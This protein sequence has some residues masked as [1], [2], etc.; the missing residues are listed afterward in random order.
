MGALFQR[1]LDVALRS[2]AFVI[3]AAA[4]AGVLAA[5]LLTWGDPSSGVLAND[6]IYGAISI[7]QATVLALLLPWTAA[8]CTAAERGDDLVLL[9]AMTAVQPSRVVLVRFA[10]VLAALAA[11]LGTGLP[12]TILAVRMSNASATQ[13]LASQALMLAI[14]VAAGAFVAVWRQELRDRL[15]AW[16]AAEASTA[17]I[18][19]IAVVAVPSLGEAAASTALLGAASLCLVGV[20]S[21]R[22]LRYLSEQDV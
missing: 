4:H 2:R 5:F 3:S 7:V 17:A 18:V 1:E 19:V 10:A 6:G 21:D 16:L 22:T 15:S 13:W 9:A 12:V 14:A 20:R 8:R 11:V